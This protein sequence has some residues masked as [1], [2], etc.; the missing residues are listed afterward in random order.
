MHKQSL[1][2]C[3]IRFEMLE[4]SGIHNFVVWSLKVY[5]DICI[6]IHISLMYRT[7][8]S[9]ADSRFAPSQWEMALLCNDVSHWQDAS[10]ESILRSNQFERNISTDTLFSNMYPAWKCKQWMQPLVA[11]PTFPNSSVNALSEKIGPWGLKVMW[12]HLA[13]T[14]IFYVDAAKRL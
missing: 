4:T 1:S 8:R 5:T 6:M 9:R 2:P 11:L 13:V 10:R 7:Y 14:V 3:C 12:C